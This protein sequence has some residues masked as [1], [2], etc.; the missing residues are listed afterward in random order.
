MKNRGF[1]IGALRP[2]TPQLLR[3]VSTGLQ[4]P[5]ASARFSP[6]PRQMLLT[7]LAA[8]A[9]RQTI[10]RSDASAPATL[11]G[12]AM[13]VR[14]ASGGY[15]HPLSEAVLDAL[16]RE[17][18]PWLDAKV[19][20]GRAVGC[21]LPPARVPLGRKRR[22]SPNHATGRGWTVRR[23]TSPCASPPMPLR[24]SPDPTTI[25]RNAPPQESR[26]RSLIGRFH[27][28]VRISAR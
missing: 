3:T 17:D 13:L 20:K 11:S 1:L 4:P 26:V 18:P 27:P 21:A 14:C 12:R 19:G 5:V 6:L 16:K 8:G 2:A 23:A 10:R 15:V 25:R 24:T 28:A 22:S 9:A 7:R